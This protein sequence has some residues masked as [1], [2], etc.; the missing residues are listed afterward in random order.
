MPLWLQ[1]GHRGIQWLKRKINARSQHKGNK[2]ALRH[3]HY[4]EQ[5]TRD[6]R[7]VRTL[8]DLAKETI[9]KM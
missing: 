2:N 4:T 5:A 7:L 8:I 6:R 3:G 9:E 1:Y